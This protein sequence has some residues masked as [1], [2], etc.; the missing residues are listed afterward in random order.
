V[1][2]IGVVLA[3]LQAVADVLEAAVVV[4]VGQAY[5]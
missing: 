4:A 1:V 5:L 3:E 2:Q